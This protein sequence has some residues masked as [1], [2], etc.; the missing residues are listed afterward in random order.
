MTVSDSQSLDI[1]A[2]A[3]LNLYLHVTGRLDNGYHSLDSLIGFVDTGDNI[4][5]KPAR[6]FA[7][8]IQGPYAGCFKH[9]ERSSE[10]ESQ[11]LAV[12]AALALAGAARKNLDFKITLT[13]NLPLAAGLGGGSAD[14][15]AV[16]RGLMQWWNIPPDAPYL[17]SL[18][19]K[20]GA[21]VPVCL[22]AETTRIQGIGNI[23]E[24]APALQSWP[25]V[26]VNPVRACSTEQVFQNFKAPFK[27]PVTLPDSFHSF[28]NMITFLAA[29]NNDLYHAASNF[30]PEIDTVITALESQPGCALARMS[31][32]GATCFGLFE[33][34]ENAKNATR[35]IQA[36]QPSWW[37]RQTRFRNA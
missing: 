36:A 35:T 19:K 16:I 18:L 27:N 25:V 13:K 15:A 11:N 22:K 31:G 2:P 3:K 24:P 21:D 10:T 5:I 17:S 8:H 20:L 32:S 37:V 6:N 7:F 12:R 14:A 28:T 34:T 33:K 23:L 4:E 1:F 30:V 29:Q 9:R 26:L